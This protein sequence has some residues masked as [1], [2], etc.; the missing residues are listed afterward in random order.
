M[1]AK[2]VW[3]SKEER[4]KLEKFSKNGVHNAHLITR[5]KT[6]LALDRTGKKDHLRIG[7]VCES[8]N[9]SRQ[10]ANNIR[11]AFFSVPSIE[12]FLTR[13]KRETPPVPAKIT[14]EVEARIIAL[15][16]NEPPKECARWTLKMLA[17]KAVELSYVDSLSFKSVQRVLKK[18]NLS[19]I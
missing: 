15:A 8:V 14:G 6:I 10:A 18:H 12:E 3:L 19:L 16:C 2:E 4:S 5:A 13:K 1:A 9:L 11:A 7:R 17:D